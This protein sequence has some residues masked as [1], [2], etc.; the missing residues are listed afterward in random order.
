MADLQQRTPAWHAARR[1][2]LTCSNLGALLG[3]VGYTSRPQAYRRATGAE[4]FEGNVACDW[5]TNNE[6]NGILAYTAKTGNL[7]QATGL[8]VHPHYKWLAGS[9]DGFVGDEGM[10]EVKCP[11]YRKRDGSI[12][13]KTVPGHYWMQINALLEITG[14]L[15]CDY[16]C[17]TANDG[18]VIYRV[19]RDPETFDFLMSWYISTYSAISAGALDVPPMSTQEKM[20][21]THR[22]EAAV[23]HGVDKHFWLAEILTNPP[24]RDDADEDEIP[25]AKRLCL[26]AAAC[27]T[28]KASD[29]DSASSCTASG[30]GHCEAAIGEASI[31]LLSL[32]HAALPVQAAAN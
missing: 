26:P 7:V 13:H 22:I 11:Y 23:E 30:V 12:L 10:I 8:H 3:Q 1:G 2:K 20:S 32:R 25:A 24:E 29:P 31:T 28:A 6:A 4:K 21:I 5:G 16:V 19:Q 27:D 9:P 15:W 17:W 14:R 18:V